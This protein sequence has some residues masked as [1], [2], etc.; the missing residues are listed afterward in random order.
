MPTHLSFPYTLY[1]VDPVNV[2]TLSIRRLT[3]SVCSI[4]TIS[5]HLATGR[6][7]VVELFPLQEEGPIRHLEFNNVQDEFYPNHV[8]KIVTER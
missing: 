5:V 2:P 6:K 7:P 3:P 4:P 8:E 1:K